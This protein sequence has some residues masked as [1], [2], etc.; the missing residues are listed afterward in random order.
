M[1]RRRRHTV[2]A[3][4][5]ALALTAVVSAPA[6][7]REAR[8]TVATPAAPGP[9]EFNKVWVDQYGPKK[10]K[11]VLVLMPGTSGGSGNFALTA[12]HLVR[13]VKGLQVWSIDRRTAALENTSVFEQALRGEVGL[14]EMF[15]YY[16]GWIAGATPPSH[17]E[18]LD[19]NNLP[20]ARQWGMKVALDDARAVVRKARA[21]GKRQVILGGHSLGASLTA[22]YAAWDFNGRPGHKDIDGMVLIDGGL[23]GSFDPFDLP[24]AQQAI[25]DLESGNPFLDLIGIGIPEASGLFAEVGSIYA[26]RAP[27]DSATTLQSFPLL[28]P[29]FNPPFPVTN[30]G[31]LGY[32]FDRDT[33]P[34]SLGLLHINGGNLSGSGNP[35]D[36]VDGGVT[37]ISRLAATFGREP[38]NGFC[39]SSRAA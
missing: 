18:F 1:Q 30:R 6:A 37:P 2:V 24:Q 15:D 12:R 13:H 20:F 25:A 28:P 16:L 9:A 35:Q 4:A 17:Y 36:W 26:Q 21:K 38:G 19:A 32:A 31:L 7:A 23:L 11:R 5:C 8:V 29:Q 33:S 27:T 10:A 22:A 39:G 3:F 14:Q 34:Q